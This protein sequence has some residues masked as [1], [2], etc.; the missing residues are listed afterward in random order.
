MP[1]FKPKTV[2]KSPVAQEKT[3]GNGAHNH[4]GHKTVSSSSSNNN[5]NGTG[6]R[7]KFG[8]Q[9]QTESTDDNQNSSKTHLVFRCQLAH[10]S[11]TGF[12]SD[13][14]NVRELY[15]KIAECYDLP[16]SEVSFIFMTFFFYHF[17]NYFSIT[18]TIRKSS[19][20]I[21]TVVLCVWEHIV[22]ISI[23]HH[24]YWMP[25]TLVMV[26]DPASVPDIPLGSKFTY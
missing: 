2:S 10:G 15:Q 8:H 12:I 22:I 17:I 16:T 26:H 21:I 6:K 25:E 18:I 13:F 20:T 11:P 1:L 3:T 14:K 24:Y 23:I 19:V 9:D 4:E 7:D 5:I